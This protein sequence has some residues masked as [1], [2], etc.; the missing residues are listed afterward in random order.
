[1]KEDKENVF[2]VIVLAN[3]T[4]L[5]LRTLTSNMNDQSDVVRLENVCVF[6]V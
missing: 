4:I 3:V 2:F 5:C 6:V 1:M